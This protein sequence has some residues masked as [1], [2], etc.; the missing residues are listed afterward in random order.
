MKSNIALKLHVVS[1]SVVVKYETILCSEHYRKVRNQRDILNITVK[2]K[3]KM[4][5]YT[6]NLFPCRYGSSI[7]CYS[8]LYVELNDGGFIS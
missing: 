6:T 7:L 4:T 2:C 1:R 5:G 8:F 3:T